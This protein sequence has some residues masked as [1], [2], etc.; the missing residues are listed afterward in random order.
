VKS[1]H[2]ENKPAALTQVDK[3][4]M[5]SELMKNHNGRATVAAGAERVG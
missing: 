5:K 3:S 1:H 2:W 4:N